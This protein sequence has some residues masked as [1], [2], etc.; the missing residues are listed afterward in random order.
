MK[1]KN[2]EPQLEE[3]AAQYRQMFDMPDL[4]SKNPEE[5]TR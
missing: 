2:F 5:Q 1:F 3:A 4:E